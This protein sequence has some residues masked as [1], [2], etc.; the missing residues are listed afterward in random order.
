MAE[1]PRAPEQPSS[2]AAEQMSPFIAFFSRYGVVV[3]GLLVLV[4]LGFHAYAIRS[5]KLREAAA[6]PAAAP[7]TTAPEPR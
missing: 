7:T 5:A 6:V 2:S 3:L 4:E 1:D